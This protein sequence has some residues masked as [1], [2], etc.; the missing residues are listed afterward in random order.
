MCPSKRRGG[1]DCGRSKMRWLRRAGSRI[2]ISIPRSWNVSDREVMKERPLYQAHRFRRHRC[3]PSLRSLV[4]ISTFPIPCVLLYSTPDGWFLASVYA[5]VGSAARRRFPVHSGTIRLRH[6]L[7]SSPQTAHIH[8]PDPERKVFDFT[9]LV[10]VKLYPFKI[11][12]GRLVRFEN[13]LP[14]VEDYKTALDEKN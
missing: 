8:L 1:R 5:R 10:Q 4:T 6:R 9:D 13:D 14:I 11:L 3:S 12:L 2:R 7:P